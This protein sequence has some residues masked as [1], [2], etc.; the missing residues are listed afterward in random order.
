MRRWWNVWVWTAHAVASVLWWVIFSHLLRTLLYIC[1]CPHL[2]VTWLPDAWCCSCRGHGAVPVSSISDSPCVSLCVHSV[3]M[4]A[5]QCSVL[6]S[7][8]YSG[9][10]KINSVQNLTF[11]SS[12]SYLL[13]LQPNLWKNNVNMYF[14]PDTLFQISSVKFLGFWL[15]FLF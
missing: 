12:G 9:P 14:F 8:H 5:L 1:H 13:K 6:P 7:T 10:T 11:T 15:F 4:S 2:I 3:H